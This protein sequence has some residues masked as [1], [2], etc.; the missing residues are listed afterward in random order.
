ML[1]LVKVKHSHWKT[2]VERDR[3]SSIL[4]RSLTV[5]FPLPSFCVL[6]INTINEANC[7]KLISTITT[8]FHLKLSNHVTNLSLQTSTV[9]DSPDTG[10]TK[11]H[12]FDP[13]LRHLSWNFDVISAGTDAKMWFFFKVKTSQ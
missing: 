12:F 1:K 2:N 6:T 5:H 3:N 10:N 13:N 8:I 4:K 11:I 7:F 9:K